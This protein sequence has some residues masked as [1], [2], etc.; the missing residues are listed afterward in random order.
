MGCN[1][2]GSKSEVIDNGEGNAYNGDI[3]GI[4]TVGERKG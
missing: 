1:G 2:V 3:G 4:W